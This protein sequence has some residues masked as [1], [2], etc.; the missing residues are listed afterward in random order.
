VQLYVSIFAAT[1]SAIAATVGIL[2]YLLNRQSFNTE[3]AWRKSDDTFRRARQRLKSEIPHLQYIAEDAQRK[4]VHIH[5]V[6]LLAEPEWLPTKPLKLDQ[7][8]LEWV[9][10][11]TTEERSRQQFEP[12][13]N[14]TRRYW[15]RS[16]EFNDTYHETIQRLE[17]PRKDLFFDGSSYR[18]LDVNSISQATQ[19]SAAF[20]LRFTTGRYFDALDTT[21]ALAYETALLDL[22]IAHGL[23][24]IPKFRPMSGPY[25]RWLGS[26]F[27]LSRRCAIPGVC[28]LTIRR[29]GTAGT[30]ILHERDPSR[31]A[32]AQGVT[33][34]TPAGEFQPQNLSATATKRD[35]DI[36][37]NIVREYAE[38]FLGLEG[39]QGQPID[40]L[41]EE[42]LIT[43]NSNLNQMYIAGEVSVHYLGIGLDPLSWKPEILTVAVFDSDA[44]DDA[45]SGI[46]HEN[47]E[48]RLIFNNERLR[49]GIPFTKEEVEHR[50]AGRMLAAGCACLRL[51]WLH[52]EILGLS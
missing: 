20:T 24:R 1:A 17:N 25:R 31:V 5:G 18:L 30:F 43:F 42:R 4:H 29:N 15:P 14:Q 39:A 51:S 41:S 21:E 37:A 9:E 47:S 33:H 36:W 2:T 49:T 7:V 40:H 13:K 52:R 10:S 32:L 44:F 38:E 8:R 45:F 16:R 11:T 22:A 6:P 23:H 19:D 27:D 28:T 26:P 48:G 3:E 34:V 50:T 35:L 12:A 46:V